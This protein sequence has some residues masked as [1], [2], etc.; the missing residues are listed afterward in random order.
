MWYTV[1]KKK[2]KIYIVIQE[3]L[4]ELHAPML[5][6]SFKQHTFPAIKSHTAGL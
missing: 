6:L 4:A 5:C 3:M 2:K 1:K